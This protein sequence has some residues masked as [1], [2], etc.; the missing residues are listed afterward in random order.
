MRAEDPDYHRRDLWEAIAAHDYPA[1]SL[2][3]QIMPY[4]DAASYRFNPFDLTKVWPHADYPPI[5]V[6]RFGFSAIQ[7]IT[8]PRSSKRLL[9]HLIWCQVPA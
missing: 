9:T 5:T 1:W 2:Q 3:M 7:R 6:G 8:S 4:E